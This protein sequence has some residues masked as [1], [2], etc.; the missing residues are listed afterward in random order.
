[1]PLCSTA[2]DNSTEPGRR[3]HQ[4]TWMHIRFSALIAMNVSITCMTLLWHSCAMSGS[5]VRNFLKTI[6]S[7]HK[8][9]ARCHAVRSA[10]ATAAMTATAHRQG[11]GRERYPRQRVRGAHPVRVA[12]KYL[13]EC[14]EGL[15]AGQPGGV[16]HHHEAVRRDALALLRGDHGVRVPLGKERKGHKHRLQLALKQHCAGACV[17][18]RHRSADGAM[19]SRRWQ[20]GAC[21]T[22]WS[23]VTVRR[24]FPHEVLHVSRRGHDAPI[25]ALAEAQG[26]P[27]HHALA[28]RHLQHLLW[29]GPVGL[30]LER[31]YGVVLE[32]RI[33]QK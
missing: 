4:S 2:H 17:R 10:L 30:L 16:A 33:I 1:M 15:G 14:A 19:P 9:N 31:A 28:D 22:T 24:T 7:C 21:P 12:H 23:S 18:G 27:P 11:G 29:L 8:K 20:G 5:A 26:R 6:I 13:P 32:G 25:Q 3:S